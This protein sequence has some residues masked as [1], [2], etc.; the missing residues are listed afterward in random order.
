MK[1][2][3]FSVTNYKSIRTKETLSS[4]STLNALIG[5]NNEGKSSFL[6]A[7]YLARHIN[8]QLLDWD[9]MRERLTDKKASPFK[10][11]LEF[12][13]EAHDYEQLADKGGGL[14][15]EKV[16]CELAL[17]GQLGFD[18]R[19]LLPT[20]MVCHAKRMREPG[21]TEEKS[22]VVLRL[23]PEQ[24]AFVVPRSGLL[25]LFKMPESSDLPL[26]P[27]EDWSFDRFRE[28]FANGLREKGDAYRIFDLLADWASRLVYVPSYR[29]TPAIGNVG[30]DRSK[31]TG[32]S[33]PAVLH[34]MKNNKERRYRVFEKM[35]QQLIPSVGRVYTHLEN[36]NQVSIR[37][38]SEEVDTAEAHRLDSVGGG[39]S[40]LIYL[41][42]LTWLSPAGSTVMIE[43]PERGLHAAS[44]RMF[45]QA[46]LAHAAEYGKTLFWST[47]STIFAPLAESCSV[48][49]ISLQNGNQ[50]QAL[51]VGEGERGAVREALGHANVDLYGYDLAVL[52][53]GESESSALPAI[54]ERLL[55]TQRFNAIHFQSLDGDL[56]SKIDSV[57]RLIESLSANQT[58]V[59]IFADDDEGTSKTIEILRRKFSDGKSWTDEQVH[60]WDCGVK[61]NSGGV[62]R[63]EFEDNFSYDELIRAANA[64]ANGGDLTVEGL[65]KYVEAAPTQKI[66]KVLEHYF[67]ETYQY[68]PS[69]PQLNKILGAEALG[70]ISAQQP[71]GRNNTK[72]EF[73]DA[74]EKLRTF[75]PRQP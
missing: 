4:L 42:A 63:A 25:A 32:E 14:Q 30:V 26:E 53:D 49:L 74:I 7:L 29:Q 43:E 1:L 20:Y 61:S 39:V 56:G 69:K 48:H 33:L 54:A 5:P 19:Y 50:T 38:A 21:R 16:V 57:C 45:M 64:V 34:F 17:T 73:E 66:S 46:A 37:V 75:L 13:L 12:V 11:S 2:T 24:K 52:W 59:F 58:R 28:L 70:K 41:V 15:V 9:Y 8:G 62:R 27:R 18:V 68:G 47:H 71:R 6:E 36:A 60:V 44:Q 40:E 31:I 10:L 67:Y 3:S 51:L 35:I 72:Y 23:N 22:M 65:T 55:G